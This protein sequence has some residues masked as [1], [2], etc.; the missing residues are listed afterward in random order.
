MTR[1][2]SH[3]RWA[4]IALASAITVPYLALFIQS[5]RAVIDPESV[6][7]ELLLELASLGASTQGDQ[8]WIAF[9][10]LAAIVGAVTLV[11]ILVIA[12]LI[13]RRQ[14]AREA[15][16]AVFGGIA[17]VAGLA[18]IGSLIGGSPSSGTWLGA[19]TAVVFIG[20]IVLLS[21]QSTSIDFELAE[22]ARQRRASG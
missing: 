17:L 8:A 11:V 19:G 2:V 10:Y 6:P 16:F 12:G 14:A 7:R 3:T 21:L 22:M 20:V 18:G 13:A 5:V 9:S 1:R 15:A 4:A